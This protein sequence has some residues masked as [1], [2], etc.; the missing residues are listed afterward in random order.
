MQQL[1]GCGRRDR[2]QL[3]AKHVRRLEQPD[4][5]PVL[6]LVLRGGA[7]PGG[8]FLELLARR[9]AACRSFDQLV[10]HACHA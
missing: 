3:G 5:L 10:G 9:L 6:L 1:G 7:S 2:A 8:E 4:Y